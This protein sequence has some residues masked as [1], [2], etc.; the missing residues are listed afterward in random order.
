VLGSIAILVSFGSCASVTQQTQ[1]QE[2]LKNASLLT[3]SIP[4]V[5]PTEVSNNDSGPGNVQTPANLALVDSKVFDVLPTKIPTSWTSEVVALPL[6][7]DHELF[8][9]EIAVEGAKDDHWYLAGEGR[10]RAGDPTTIRIFESTGPQS[11]WTEVN[12]GIPKTI[13]SQVTAGLRFREKTVFVGWMGSPY[14][15]VP[16]VVITQTGKPAEI[17]RIPTLSGVSRPSALFQAHDTLYMTTTDGTEGSLLQS[18]NGLSWTESTIERP[19]PNQIVSYTTVVGVGTVGVLVS[20]HEPK[21]GRSTGVFLYS[22]A[23]SPFTRIQ[24]PVFRDQHVSLWPET[25]GYMATPMDLAD[26]RFW[27]SEEGK[28][29]SGPQPAESSAVVPSWAL[30]QTGKRLVAMRFRRAD[31]Q[32]GWTAREETLNKGYAADARDGGA[33]VVE[34]SRALLILERI[35]SNGTLTQWSTDGIPAHRADATAEVTTL[36]A[37]RETELALVTFGVRDKL[38]GNYKPEMYRRALYRREGKRWEPTKLLTGVNRVQRLGAGFVIVLEG[39]DEAP[40]T[41]KVTLDGKTFNEVTLND[42]KGFLLADEYGIITAGTSPNETPLFA[43]YGDDGKAKSGEVALDWDSSDP[44]IALCADANRLVVVLESGEVHLTERSGFDPSW[45]SRPSNLDM[46]NA[47]NVMCSVANG[48][49]TIAANHFVSEAADYTV[50]HRTSAQANGD[51]DEFKTATFPEIEGASSSTA[52]LF[53]SSD[54]Y[55]YVGGLWESQVDRGSIVLGD[56]MTA[57]IVEGVTHHMSQGPLETSQ[58]GVDTRNGIMIGGQL[59]DAAA[60]WVEN[61]R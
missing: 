28:T 51:F 56:A 22:E 5:S 7:G 48:R 2:K 49:T 53:E 8:D 40:F 41:T 61:S 43:F 31:V 1:P 32:L 52:Y 42:G 29:W 12:T 17:V 58:T 44:A 20:G 3:S 39:T 47:S 60:I 30:V 57:G 11:S 54:G 45:T 16:I 25:G 36:V 10:S 24:L 21:N 37:N 38:T 46:V 50:F 9:A 35:Q 18:S 15:M 4:E 59:A 55:A 33:F 26:L 6:D 34:Q 23:G 13:G 19:N 27:R 14:D